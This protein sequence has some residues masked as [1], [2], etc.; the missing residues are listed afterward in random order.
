MNKVVSHI[1]LAVLLLSITACKRHLNGPNYI[2]YITDEKNGLNKMVQIGDWEFEMLYKPSDYIMYM[3]SKGDKQYDWNT[4]SK[5]LTGTVW[6]NI[7]FKRK[8][9]DV[10]PLKYNVSSLEE[11]NMR[12]NYF[13]NYAPKDIALLYG[14]DT[15]KPMSYL[16][17]TNYN[18]TPQETMVVGFDLPGRPEAPQKDMQLVY[19]DQVFKNGFIKATYSIES[20]DKAPRLNK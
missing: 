8:S 17:E 14:K 2:K 16:F 10:S 4:R 18:L 1:F 5:N 13:L 9:A 7:S 3:E 15:I 12:L 20:I 11:Y 19:Y 6:F